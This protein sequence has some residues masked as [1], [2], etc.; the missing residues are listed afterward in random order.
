MRSK[1]RLRP[2]LVVVPVLVV[3]VLFAARLW[4]QASSEFVCSAGANDGRACTAQSDC[5]GGACVITQGVCSDTAGFP[6]DCPGSVCSGT[7]CSGGV[8][9]G[10]TCD[11]TTNCDTGVSCVGTQKVCVGNGT[12]S[13][14]NPAGFSCLSNAQCSSGQ[15]V[16]TGRVCADGTDFA[17]FACGQDADCCASGTSCNPSGA[18][19]APAAG[20]PSATVTARTPTI[21]PSASRTGG[22]STP[23]PPASASPTPRTP[24]P[25]GSAPPSPTSTPICPASGECIVQAVGEGG[26]CTL[27]SPG[28]YGTVALAILTGILLWA[29]RVSWGRKSQ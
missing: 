12:G 11:T 26:G 20:T 15:C 4:A 3:S 28:G 1:S 22:I 16:S 19:V 10:G 29:R 2:K 25:A 27:G 8:F 18:C 6:C 9:A 21:T 23:T 7:T 5:P 14:G 13:N 24:T 17:G